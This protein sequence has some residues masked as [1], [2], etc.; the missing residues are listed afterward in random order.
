[1]VQHPLFGEVSKDFN[2]AAALEA[3]AFFNAEPEYAHVL[4]QMHAH[5]VVAETKFLHPEVVDELIAKK[6]E[7]RKELLKD[8]II[9]GVVNKSMSNKTVDEVVAT[10]EEI[11]KDF[12]TEWERSANTAKQ[13]RDVRGRFIKMGTTRIEQPAPPPSNSK[14]EWKALTE[15]YDRVAMNRFQQKPPSVGNPNAK[16]SANTRQRAEFDAKHSAAWLQV[17][18]ALK[19]VDPAGLVMADVTMRKHDPKTGAPT[20]QIATTTRLGISA[21]EFIKPDEYKDGWVATNIDWYV[22]ADSAFGGGYD[23]L[24]GAGMTGQAYV[25]SAGITHRA[26][27]AVKAYNTTLKSPIPDEEYGQAGS[28]GYRRL[29]ATATMIDAI[30]GDALGGKTKW[31]LDAAKYVGEHGP[32]AEKVLGPTARRTAY[33]YRGVERYPDP[34]LERAIGASV[35]GSKS[36]E[37][38][39]EKLVHPTIADAEGPR[40]VEG[41]RY[42]AGKYEQDLVFSPFIR[43]W[44]SQLPKKENLNLHL[45]SGAIA[46]S[47]GVVFDSKGQVVTQAVGYGDDHY[48]P[49][50]LKNLSRANRGEWV[51]TRTMGGPTT[52]DIYAALTTGTRSVTVVS[53]SGVYNIEFDESF[54]GGRRYND[55]AARMVRRYSQL[56]DTLEAENTTLMEIP[57]DRYAELKAKAQAEFPG[58]SPSAVNERRNRLT[59]LT[60]AER[61]EPKPSAFQKEQ[62]T[63]EFGTNVAED[64]AE[65]YS[66]SQKFPDD[67]SWAQLK[68]NA[69]IKANRLLTDEEAI[70][71]LG[72]EK[73]YERFMAGKVREYEAQQKPLKLNGQGY[74]FALQALQ[75]Q[76]PYYI[77][78]VEWY[79]PN[80]GAGGKD[81][82]YVKRNFL[83]S[84]DI[85]EGYW[86]PEI[87]GFTG[88]E[89][90]GSGKYSGKSTGKVPANHT[91]FQ[92]YANRQ[93]VR[94]S[95][96][97]TSSDGDNKDGST[98]S[99]DGY[100]SPSLLNSIGTAVPLREYRDAKDVSTPASMEAT[101][102]LGKKM[103]NEMVKTTSSGDPDS[104]TMKRL[105]SLNIDELP[106]LT[107]WERTERILNT[108]TDAERLEVA[109]GLEEEFDT[110]FV[111]TP[112]VGGGTTSLIMSTMKKMFASEYEQG[113]RPKRAIAPLGAKDS[114]TKTNQMF[115]LGP[116]FLPGMADDEYRITSQKDADIDRFRARVSNG[117]FSD[118]A[119]FIREVAAADDALRQMR[120]GT[121]TS[122]FRYGGKDYSRGDAEMLASDVERDTVGFLKDRQLAM[123]AGITR[124]WD[125]GFSSIPD[126]VE[127]AEEIENSTPSYENPDLEGRVW[128]ETNWKE[129]AN[130]RMEGKNVPLPVPP[131]GWEWEF[132]PIK[133]NE[134]PKPKGIRRMDGS[135]G[136]VLIKV[137]APASSFEKR[138]S[139]RLK[140]LN[141]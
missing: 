63:E 13:R 29:N 124:V 11:Q 113:V 131:A 50:N 117:V 85:K 36:I 73:R 15:S 104:A 24:T 69:S 103:S 97:G 129:Y 35:Q 59:Q 34:K 128:L 92:N 89:S 78:R 1:M 12:Y 134:R 60:N 67:V 55:K 123:V 130:N 140:P 116:K 26:P 58:D 98:G 96:P 75:E 100:K 57:P 64:F 14:E 86:D 107:N 48:L 56:L 65:R 10:M 137:T 77:K 47:Q 20:D 31:A 38:A 84:A 121:R 106:L 88:T 72:L 136:T 30:G 135:G 132:H 3:Y 68:A 16:S 76:F 5:D 43:Y 74:Y 138:L 62:W 71:E 99:T 4:L 70:R 141:S 22:D 53:H 95:V 109:K 21:D 19:R 39:R 82:G 33:R 110:I 32:E 118:E 93:K 9:N 42:L 114:V 125:S 44:Q 41:D 8:S 139:L 28:A 79:P 25:D 83:R 37:D 66:N 112:T 40:Q 46:P 17:A 115:N 90:A 105:G 133:N 52:E 49:F 108:G 120:S 51:R 6:F 27:G 87:E 101:F 18:D 94:S 122:A 111:N 61:A 102:E 23:L 54:R 7:A 119:T 126:T 127:E 2:E 91:N 45:A 81:K 80:E